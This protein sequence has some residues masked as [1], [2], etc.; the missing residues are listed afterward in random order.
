MMIIYSP[1]LTIGAVAGLIAQLGV[2]IAGASGS[3]KFTLLNLLLAAYD[4]YSGSIQYDDHELHSISSESL[5]DIVSVI[6]QNVVIFNASI[7]D[8]VT[9]FRDVLQKEVDKV[10]E[11]AGLLSFIKEHGE[12]YLC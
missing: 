6:Q 7:R 12:D 8:N 11:M 1:L 4:N 3:G 2:F 5:Y 9:M 10:I